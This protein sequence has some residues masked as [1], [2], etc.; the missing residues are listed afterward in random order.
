MG[1][2]WEG[3]QKIPL[4]ISRVPEGPLSVLGVP[5][6]VHGGSLGDAWRS[7]VDRLRIPCSPGSPWR[8]P[9]RFQRGPSKSLQVPK[10]FPLG[11]PKSLGA[12]EGLWR[13]SGDPWRVD[14]CRV[15]GG[16]MEVRKGPLEALSYKPCAVSSVQLLP[17]GS[18]DCPRR[19]PR[20]PDALCSKF[21]GW[22]SS[23]SN[24]LSK[25]TFPL[26]TRN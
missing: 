9:G 21:R 3:P 14:S 12:L 8:L 5:L 22:D 11:P 24:N 15:S 2:P 20:S 18:L 1:A 26:D 13:V 16:P 6:D 23:F 25:V 10:G 7:M 4:G 19:V 17:E